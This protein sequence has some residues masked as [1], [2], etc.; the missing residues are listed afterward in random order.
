MQEKNIIKIAV[1]GII[2]YLIATSLTLV[3][4]SLFVF[5]NSIIRSESKIVIGG[6]HII[7]GILTA[8][9]IIALYNKLL[10]NKVPSNGTVI[11][12]FVLMLLV[13]IGALLLSSLSTASSL[14]GVS[15]SVVTYAFHQELNILSAQVVMPLTLFIYFL[16]KIFRE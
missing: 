14:S 7:L 12:S 1:T 3:F 16:V 15:S 6:V 13:G 4:N 11:I 8:I 2:F 9:F 10:K 5:V